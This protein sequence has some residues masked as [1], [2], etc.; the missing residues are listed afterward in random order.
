MAATLRVRREYVLSSNSKAM[1][2]AAGFF[3]SLMRN[4]SRPSP[5]RDSR[6]ATS[7]AMR[8]ALSTAVRPRSSLEN[9]A[10]LALP[11]PHILAR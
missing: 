11:P 7:F 6:S 4:R 1:W 9:Y 8:L 3:A 5:A 2:P 10:R